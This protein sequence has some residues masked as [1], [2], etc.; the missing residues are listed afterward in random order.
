MAGRMEK[1]VEKFVGG[2]NCSQAILSAYCDLYGLD[3]V[4]AFKLAEGFG[5]GMGGFKDEC[6]AVTGTFMVLGLSNSDG[7]LGKG[8]TKL[9]TYAK[10]KAA[11]QAFEENFESMMF[12]DLLRKE[13]GMKAEATPE[14]LERSNGKNLICIDCVKWAAEYLDKELAGTQ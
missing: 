8:T 11:G 2:Y 1:A 5:L 3:E 9:D 6:G 7:D 13:K 4:T 10:I 12:R 14:Q